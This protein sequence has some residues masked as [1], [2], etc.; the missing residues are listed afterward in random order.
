M[1]DKV[2]FENNEFFLLRGFPEEPQRKDFELFGSYM[3]ACYRYDSNLRS[4]AAA[5]TKIDNPE[6]LK[7]QLEWVKG[8]HGNKLFPLKDGDIF[9]IPDNDYFIHLR[10]KQ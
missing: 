9:D 7:E 10:L 2:L 4:C 3:L 5:K 1:K 8:Q 6:L